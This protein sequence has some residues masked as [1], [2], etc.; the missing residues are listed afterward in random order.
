MR[1]KSLPKNC[2]WLDLRAAV[3]LIRS[4]QR[5]HRHRSITPDLALTL[6]SANGIDGPNPLA[7]LE[8]TNAMVTM[9]PLSPQNFLRGFDNVPAQMFTTAPT[10]GNT[11]SLYVSGGAQMRCRSVPLCP[12]QAAT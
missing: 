3:E 8:P 4:R 12:L 1:W 5:R 7:V 10:S 9:Q 6:P 11:D 2:E